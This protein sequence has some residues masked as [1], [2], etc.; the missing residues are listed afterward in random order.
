M[1]PD[2]GPLSYHCR[3][4]LHC[5]KTVGHIDALLR[6][7]PEH[8]PGQAAWHDGRALRLFLDPCARVCAF[9]FWYSRC[10]AVV[11]VADL[12]PV[13][14]GCRT[15]YVTSFAHTCHSAT[16]VFVPKSEARSDIHKSS[17]AMVISSH[18]QKLELAENS[19]VWR[20]KTRFQIFTPLLLVPS[21]TNVT[22]LQRF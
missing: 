22:N 7:Q 8:H 5:D 2:W 9:S 3:P 14:S 12:I 15:S 10:V 17:F 13:W 11:N 16:Q 4:V 6:Q 18:T 1:A 19:H 21:Q 20:Q